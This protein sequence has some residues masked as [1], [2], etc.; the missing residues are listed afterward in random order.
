MAATAAIGISLCACE[1]KDKAS[2]QAA[3]DSAR[4]AAAKQPADFVPQGHRIE[5]EMRGDLDK[6]GV[7]DVALLIH[8]TD[9]NSYILIILFGESDGY[10][11]AYPKPVS[12]P[13]IFDQNGNRINDRHSYGAHINR[14]N[15]LITF[16]LERGG[17]RTYTFRHKNGSFELIGFD[18]SGR[19]GAAA[20]WSESTNYLTS[21]RKSVRG[22]WDEKLNDYKYTETWSTIKTEPLKK[23]P[24]WAVEVDEPP[25]EG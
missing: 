16:Y 8:G 5:K 10:R 12:L 21:K 2:K 11:T 18:E 20:N 9:Q 23:L 24:D 22:K 19:D 4:E 3:A 15:L 25:W 1:E 14:G 7:E 13:P 6:D 17:S